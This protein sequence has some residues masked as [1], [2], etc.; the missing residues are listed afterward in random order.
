MIY[1]EKVLPITPWTSL[2]LNC[3]ITRKIIAAKKISE[4]LMKNTTLT[5]LNLYCDGKIIENEI[6]NDNSDNSNDNTNE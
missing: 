1:I 4:L 2:D 3:K 6:T 5:E